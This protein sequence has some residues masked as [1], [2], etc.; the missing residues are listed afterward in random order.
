MKIFPLKAGAKSAPI[1]SPG[2]PG[3]MS[4]PFFSRHTKLLPASSHSSI[5]LQQ[6]QRSFVWLILP[7]S[8]TKVEPIP[9]SKFIQGSPAPWRRA[10]GSVNH[11]IA[12]PVS[13]RG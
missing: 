13:R 3:L 9:W 8:W 11:A 5:F 6:G 4:S 2:P 1:R 7:R 10:W 12:R